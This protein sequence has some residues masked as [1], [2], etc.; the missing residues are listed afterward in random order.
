MR[1][2][3]GHNALPD[4]PMAYT[5]RE[6]ATA[7]I[8]GRDTSGLGGSHAPV[9]RA[10]VARHAA[11]QVLTRKEAPAHIGRARRRGR[12]GRRLTALAAG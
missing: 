2:P 9:V 1:V 7:F 3:F 12:R 4:L 5:A 11:R 10:A 6:H 8:A